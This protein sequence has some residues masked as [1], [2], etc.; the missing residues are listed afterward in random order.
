[1]TMKQRQRQRRGPA[2]RAYDPRAGSVTPSTS[3]A[4]FAAFGA[5]WGTWGAALPSVRD[6]TGVTDGQL[7]SSLLLVGLGALPAM[8]LAGAAVDRWGSR[9]TA[10]ALG[11]LALTGVGLAVFAHSPATL[12]AAL[13]LVGVTS[14]AADVGI[15]TLA[16]SVQR[17]T[18]RPTIMR[19]QGAFSCSV[20]GSSLLSGALLARGA[21]PLAPF[22]VVG[23][24]SL[25]AVLVVASH[26]GHDRPDPT[27]APPTPG[28][29]PAAP[30]PRSL[31]PQ[32]RR[33]S[34]LVG[35]LGALG[36][37]IENAH[38]SWG[39]V[40]LT[41]VIGSGSSAAAAAPAVFAGTVAL[42]R[43]GS[44]LVPA[45]SATR[46]LAA[47]A[48]LAA[49]GTLLLA[50]STSLVVALAG[51]A[52]AAAGTAVLF[53]TAL[54]AATAGVQESARGQATATVTVV[55]YLG[56]L[57]GPVYVGWSSQAAGLRVAMV[58]VAALAVI[59]ALLARPL[60]AASAARK[61]RP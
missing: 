2:G 14:G 39:A 24:A 30:T 43:L 50:A 45:R 26:R 6:Q 18:G 55:A 34:I 41:D 3:Y 40:F 12:A 48:S 35:V 60:L 4:A 44:S 7:G 58:A 21:P 37:A 59:L 19:A 47:G 46:V 32:V 23:L 8:L 36:F 61:D 22:A 29:T 16:G 25:A 1:M 28:S 13:L 38:Q 31:L 5:F 51:I 49:L 57:L 15:N 56:F 10:A 17:A 11:S 27:P 9:A 54:G 42:A 33:A 53:P 52:I 20:V